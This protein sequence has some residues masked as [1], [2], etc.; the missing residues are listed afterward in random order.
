VYE[1]KLEALRRHRTQAELQDVPFE[2]WREIIATEAFVL[3]F[4]E[5]EPGGRVLR[6]VFEDL[7]DG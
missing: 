2:L 4:P 5:R 1:R 3:A 6:D 7:A